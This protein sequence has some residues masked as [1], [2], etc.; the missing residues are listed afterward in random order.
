MHS[1]PV[2]FVIFI[3]QVES[4]IRLLSGERSLGYCE[5]G[6]VLAPVI[7]VVLHTL[8]SIVSPLLVLHG[9]SLSCYRAS[10]TDGGDC[11]PADFLG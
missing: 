4:C 1:A 9:S 5:N 10:Y 3:Y 11:F 7:I 8:G 6:C 2:I